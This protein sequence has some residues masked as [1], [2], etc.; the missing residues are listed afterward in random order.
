[1]VRF[2]ICLALVFGIV[3]GTT[4]NMFFYFFLY[5]K[6]FCHIVIEEETTN[7]S[8]DEE[9]M[10]S[11]QT[12][13]TESI[14][15]VESNSTLIYTDKE[16]V[17]EEEI[18]I[19]AHLHN[20]TWGVNVTPDFYK[21]ECIKAAMTPSQLENHQLC[22]VVAFRDSDDPNDHGK[23]RNEQLKQFKVE[24]DREMKLRNVNYTLVIAE[25]EKGLFFNRGALMNLGFIT[26]YHL[27]DYFIFHDVDLI[28]TSKQNTYGYPTKPTHCY[29]S[30]VYWK[31]QQEELV[32]G[33]LLMTQEQYV[34]SNG[35]SNYYW[36][37]GYEDN[38][39][40]HRIKYSG[41]SVYRLSVIA[42]KYKQL[43]HEHGRVDELKKRPQTI[44][45]ENY[46]IY[47][48]SYNPA[49]EKDGLSNVN[50]T[51]VAVLEKDP[52]IHMVFRLNDHFNLLEPLNA[53]TN[54]I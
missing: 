50:A 41:Q 11:L 27:C 35:F 49:F 1:M 31:Q 9:I 45:S 10:E 52:S 37:W 14:E 20:K 42:G 2:R 40:Y 18:D 7:I 43:K 26:T 15:Y 13:V 17:I 53:T 38:D 46:Y 25:Q 23:G 5:E 51:I 3:L 47:C 8:S 21:K 4:F 36:G 16:P 24:M 34:Q 48:K 6:S 32:G 12:V 28:P 19:C 39:M 54:G 33:V 44:I 22:I 30:T 29:T